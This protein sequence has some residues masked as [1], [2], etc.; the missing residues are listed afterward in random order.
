M[1]KNHLGRTGF[2][3]MKGSGW[4]LKLATASGQERPLVKASVV[5]DGPE[6]KKRYKEVEACHNEENMRELQTLEQEYVKLKL[7]WVLQDA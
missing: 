3:G 4:Q 5:A 1:S 7:P 2:E 6:L